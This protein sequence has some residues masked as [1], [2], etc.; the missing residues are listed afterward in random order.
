MNTVNKIGRAALSRIFGSNKFN[1]VEIRFPSEEFDLKQIICFKA[2]NHHYGE[3][4][5]IT[6]DCVYLWGIEL[7]LQR[8]ERLNGNTYLEA[9][10]EFLAKDK[11]RVVYPSHIITCSWVGGDE[12]SNKDETFTIFR[13]SQEQD[14]MIEG[15]NPLLISNMKTV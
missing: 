13:F 6:G 12:F 1:A 4:Q 15:L 9:I 14:R 2:L 11:N 8:L 5:F 7:G 3:T 10:A